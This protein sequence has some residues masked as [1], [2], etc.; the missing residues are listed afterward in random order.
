MGV[1]PS[2]DGAFP[3]SGASL[4][5]TIPVPKLYTEGCDEVRN[6]V[7]VP[8]RSRPFPCPPDGTVFETILPTPAFCD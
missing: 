7:M 5:E 3:P 4:L 1:Y 8:A 2:Q 6:G